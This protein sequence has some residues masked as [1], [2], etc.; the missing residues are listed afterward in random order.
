MINSIYVTLRNYGYKQTEGPQSDQGKLVLC[1][2]NL[3][4]AARWDPNAAGNCTGDWREAGVVEDVFI[5]AD[6][7]SREV[8]VEWRGE[9]VPNAGHYCFI[10]RWVSDADPMHYV[11]IEQSVTNVRYNNN[12]AWKN[13]DVANA[14][15]G[16]TPSYVFTARPVAAGVPTNLVIRP[17]RPFNGTIVIDLDALGVSAANVQGE[18]ILSRSG[19]RI[20][21]MGSGGRLFDLNVPIGGAGLKISFNPVLGALP[22]SFPVSVFQEAVLPT[23]ILPLAPD[24]EGAGAVP[25]NGG[26]WSG[27]GSQARHWWGA[28]CGKSSP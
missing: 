27:A 15:P 6:T 18:G 22:A 14:P 11:E 3:G 2:T 1:Y 4:G 8:R 20:F 25:A 16:R 24:S 9:D 23:T 17:E 12:I 10:A 7:T 5:S 26:D 19:T 13:F 21:L 28:V